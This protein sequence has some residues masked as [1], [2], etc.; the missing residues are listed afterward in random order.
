[1]E[2]ILL[3]DP[4]LVIL[5]REII[6]TALPCHLALIIRTRWGLLG[7]ASVIE[8]RVRGLYVAEG[9]VPVDVSI[10]IIYVTTITDDNRDF[11]PFCIGGSAN[12]RRSPRVVNMVLKEGTITSRDLWHIAYTLFR[13][14]Q[15]GFG[16]GMHRSRPQGGGCPRAA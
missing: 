10:N 4:Q 13:R 9:G 5:R 11:A 16:R 15:A 1:M 2:L 12:N 3:F 7:L 8:A 6:P 14:R